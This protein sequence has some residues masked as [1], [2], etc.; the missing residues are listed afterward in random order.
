VKQ[1]AI[2]ITP[3]VRYCY[4]FRVSLVDFTDDDMEKLVR[5]VSNE[6]TGREKVKENDA[7]NLM[8]DAVIAFLSWVQQEGNPVDHKNLVGLSASAPNLELKLVSGRFGRD[9]LKHVA[10]LARSTPINVKVPMPR[11]IISKIEDQIY[12]ESDPETFLGA[13]P[14]KFKSGSE[15]MLM[16]QRY[17][18]ERR[19]FCLWLFKR[20]GLRTEELSLMPLTNN[21]DVVKTL[22]MWLPTKKRR[23]DGLELRP[24][25]LTPQ[26]GLTVQH[27]LDARE[28]YLDYLKRI[29]RAVL[30]IDKMMVTE[31]GLFLSASSIT[32]DFSRIIVRSGVN[33]SRA[34]LSMFRHRFITMEIMAHMK[35]LLK[36]DKP[37]R[38]MLNDAV[39]KSIEERVR[40]KT[41]HKLGQSIWNY[42]DTAFDMMKFWGGV[43][44]T[45]SDVARIEDFE[46]G[47]RRIEYKLRGEPGQSSVLAEELAAL[48]KEVSELRRQLGVAN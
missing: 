9:S 31:D 28:N 23:S 18:Y 35:D 48:R 33:D 5:R 2:W 7:V 30:Y 41:G 10:R 19:F 34:C 26:A 25:K 44:K 16:V 38:G 12:L 42:F 15:P 11:S 47:A 20:T 45:L 22:V 13:H 4:E 27:Y 6:T 29:G 1:Y 43:E 24:F 17:L 46:D 32:R 40:K 36:T 14:H 3:Y 8:I 37:T 21:L 39:I